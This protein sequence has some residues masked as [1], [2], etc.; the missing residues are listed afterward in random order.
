MNCFNF[1]LQELVN[2]N[3]GLLY[4]LGASHNRLQEICSVCLEYGLSAKLTGAGGG[5][6]AFAFLPSDFKKDM[7]VKLVDE[8]THKNY[9]VFEVKLGEEGVRLEDLTKLKGSR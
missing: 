4:S 2:I 7:F 3:Q 8:L 1:L 6:C 5:G 9:E